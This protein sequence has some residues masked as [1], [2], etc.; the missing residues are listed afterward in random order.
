MLRIQCP[1]CQRKFEG[2]DNWAGKRIKCACG[3]RIRMPGEE[4]SKFI[5]CPN[6][7]CGYSGPSRPEARGSTFVGVVLLLFW[8]LPGILYLL[9]TGGYRH[10]CPRCGLQ[11]IQEAR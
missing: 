1:S 9:L 4:G 5:I 7:N 6:V 3:V 11:V 2:D 8:I 10:Y